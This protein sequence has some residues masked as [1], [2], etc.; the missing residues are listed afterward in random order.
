M[1][2]LQLA[3]RFHYHYERLAP[4]FGYDTKPESK[5]PWE[6]VPEQN[7]R[8]MVATASAVLNDLLCQVCVEG[9]QETAAELHVREQVSERVAELTL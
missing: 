3:Q 1:T 4:R 2:A 9:R 8:L 6:V 7:Q 5:K